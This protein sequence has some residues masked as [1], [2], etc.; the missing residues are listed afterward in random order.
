MSETDLSDRPGWKAVE[1]WLKESERPVITPMDDPIAKWG[2]RGLV[3]GGAIAFA[4]LTLG[5]AF[6]DDP[7]PAPHSY[8][9]LMGVLAIPCSIAGMLVGFAVWVYRRSRGR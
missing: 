4:F 3:V 7:S 1:R 9:I 5:F 2:T 6:E 8:P